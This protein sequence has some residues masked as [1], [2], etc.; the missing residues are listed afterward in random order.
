LAF[1]RA[2]S[3]NEKPYGLLQPLDN[4][5]LRWERINVD[6]ITKLLA[7]V[8]DGSGI[9][10]NDTIITFI[11]SLTKWAHWVAAQESNITAE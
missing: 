8:D 3:S 5:S 7:T 9:A 4:P 2:K 11:N 10:G 1:H 6:F